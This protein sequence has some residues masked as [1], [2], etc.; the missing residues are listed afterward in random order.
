MG[1]GRSFRSW[2]AAG[3]CLLGVQSPAWGLDLARLEPNRWNEVRPTWHYLPGIGDGAY[4]GRGWGTLRAIPRRGTVVFYEGFGPS[5]R[6]DYCIY[7]NTLYEF[8]PATE[9]VDMLSIGNWY[10][11]SGR[12]TVALPENE[13]VPTPKDR[14]TYAQFAYV[15]T[16]DAVYLAA[17]ASSSGGHPRDFWRFSLSSR[18]WEKLGDIPADIPDWD[19]ICERNLIWSSG[20]NR[21]YFFVGANA[22][23]AFDLAARKWKKLTTQGRPKS[24]GSHGAYDPRRNRFAFYG[25]NWTPD[26][27]GSDALVLFDVGTATWADEPVSVPW[28]PAKSYA[29][30]EYIDRYDAY[31]LHGGRGHGDTWAYLP[32]QRRWQKIPAMSPPAPGGVSTYLAYDTRND[33]LI[34]FSGQSMSVM[35]W[36]P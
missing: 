29:A 23:Y 17:G 35:R 15:P 4:Q 21:L 5:R 8:D 33:I 9:R 19:C 31:L 20:D 26:G 18:Q 6:G 10:C 13:T 12:P 36:I 30:L 11:Q 28:P 24:I 22:V 25:N 27:K 1:F 7:A 32:A 34:R 14:H 3:V 2:V 16:T